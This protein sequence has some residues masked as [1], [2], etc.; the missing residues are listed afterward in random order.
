MSHWTRDEIRAVEVVAMLSVAFNTI[1][2]VI[3]FVGAGIYYFFHGDV[4][5][6]IMFILVAIFFRMGVMKDG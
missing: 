4:E 3:C 5:R 6:T 1:A 2:Y